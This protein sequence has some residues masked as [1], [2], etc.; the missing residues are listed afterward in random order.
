MGANPN[1][2]RPGMMSG[3]GMMNNPLH[4]QLNP[5]L[6]G[7]SNQAM[8]G[9]SGFNNMGGMPH[10]PGHHMGGV[11]GTQMGMQM[12]HMPVTGM[13]Q[14]HHNQYQQ[15]GMGYRPKTQGYNNNKQQQQQQQQQY[16]P[17]PKQREQQQSELQKEENHQAAFKANSELEDINQKSINIGPNSKFFVIKSYSEDNIIMSIK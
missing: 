14:Y 16:K 3:M 10:M 15:N 11:P 8:G 9:L 17:K 1:Q 7:L 4:L 5:G 13:N 6:G 12:P 2:Q